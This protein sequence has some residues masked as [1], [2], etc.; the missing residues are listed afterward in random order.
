VFFLFNWMDDLYNRSSWRMLAV[1][2][3]YT[4]GAILYY[5]LLEGRWGATPGKFALGL[6]VVGPD[7]HPPGFWRALPRPL[8][9]VVAPTLPFW[10]IYGAN[11][12]AYMSLSTSV[13]LLASSPLYILLALM[14]CTMR[15]KN[16][17]AAVHDLVTKTRVISK[18]RTQARPMPAVSD[19]S[20]PDIQARPLVGPYHVL[21]TLE[22][23]AGAALLLGYDLR[24]LRKVW[25][26]TAPAGAPPFP[27]PLRN[28]GRPGRL[29]WLAGRRSTDENWDAF[30][31]LSGQPLLRLLQEQPRIFNP[32]QPPDRN[33]RPA[34]NPLPWAQ[35]RY[36][37]CDLASELSAAKK[38]ASLPAILDL[39]RVWICADGRAKLL[40]F[41]APGLAASPPMPDTSNASVF[42]GRVA[43][44]ALEGR[45]DAASQPPGA[46]AV[47]LPAHVRKFL[48]ALPQFPDP[49]TLLLAL[50]P[51]LQ[52]ATE[53]TRLRRAIILVGCLLFPLF[54]ALSM[55]LG[56]AF[57]EQW[58]LSNPGL[59]QLSQLLQQRSAMRRWPSN[60]RTLPTDRQFAIYISSHYRAAVTNTASWS[61]AFALSIIKGD[62]R[63]FA[64]QSIVQYPAPTD[65]EI[66]GADDALKTTTVPG[67]EVFTMMRQPAFIIMA[68]IA[69]LAF[70]VALPAVIAAL[71][72]RGG[73]VLL[74]A[75]VTFVRRDG[76]PASRGR[77]LLRAVITWIPLLPALILSGFSIMKR[78]GL[79]VLAIGMLSCLAILSAALPKRG[80]QDRLAGTWPVLR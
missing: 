4:V 7:N 63:S 9:Y 77:L 45:P 31:A 49:D 58:N 29:R 39:D 19:A 16:G 44:A 67:I 6:R 32:S 43:S 40:D 78:P 65:S 56:Q 35:V 46:V 68:M 27:V 64:E 26:R 22:T 34:S 30:E 57:V 73:L 72:F 33:P 59:F 12:K 18:P 5:A 15:R 75:G 70:Y 80:L 50:R 47:P 62:N 60:N 37:L 53:V 2:L 20:T 54:G 23:S 3:A 76:A 79:A 28:L 52:R 41:P 42:L 38:D 69:S 17:F 48:G 13:Q 36:W 1:I 14:F 24:L 21:E 51:L 66:A 8:L 74:A 25:I 61:S 10:L 71:A 55:Y 11:L